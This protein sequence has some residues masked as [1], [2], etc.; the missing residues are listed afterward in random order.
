MIL[1]T[2]VTNRSILKTA[3]TYLLISLF[4]ALFGAIY[5]VFS[6]GVYSNF[7]IYA[8]A[9]PLVGGCLPFFLLG[10]WGYNRKLPTSL[11]RNLYHSGI[12]TLTVG[13]VIR[14]VLEIYGTTNAL[15]DYYWIVGIILV[16]AGLINYLLSPKRSI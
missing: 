6:Y 10:F 13:S 12:A 5:E 3:F 14:G 2:S 1:S 8:F 9:F 16:T 4:V 7:M 11:S 15:S